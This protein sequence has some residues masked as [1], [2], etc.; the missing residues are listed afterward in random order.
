MSLACDFARTKTS[1]DNKLT[2]FMVTEHRVNKLINYIYCWEC[3]TYRNLKS[4]SIEHERCIR[5][6]FPDLGKTFSSTLM[7]ATK[8]V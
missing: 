3:T 6:E 2:Q 4:E 5:V 1:L 8:Q 7:C